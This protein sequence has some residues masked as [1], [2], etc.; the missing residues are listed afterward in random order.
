MM[1]AVGRHG[2]IGQQTMTTAPV[3]DAVRA[4]AT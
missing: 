1:E 3:A 4:S 2:H